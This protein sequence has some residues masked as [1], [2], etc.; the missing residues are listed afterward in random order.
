MNTYKTAFCN[1]FFEK[2]HFPGSPYNFG[3]SKVCADTLLGFQAQIPT[4]CAVASS[5][6]TST[7]SSSAAINGGVS[8]AA[9]VKFGLSN[10]ASVPVYGKPAESTPM[11]SFAP[12]G[13]VLQSIIKLAKSFF[14]LK[15]K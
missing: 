10:S 6:V 15:L 12:E 8:S 4:T 5:V 1:A 11:L 2:H 9:V 3:T 7:T 14:L 13:F